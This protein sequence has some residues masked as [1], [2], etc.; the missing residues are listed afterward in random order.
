MVVAVKTQSST[1]PAQR[2]AAV[3]VPVLAI[4]A[5]LALLAYRAGGTN[6]AAGVATAAAIGLWLW[7]ARRSYR[8]PGSG[9]IRLLVDRVGEPADEEAPRVSHR[10]IRIA[11]AGNRPIQQIEVRLAECTPTPAWFVPV[12]LQRLR[13][14]AHPFDLSPRTEVHIDLLA[15]PHGHPEII[16]V[17]DSS[18]HG[19]LPNG[20][21]LGPLELTVQVTARGLP[22]ASFRFAAS[23]TAAGKLELVEKPQLQRP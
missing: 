7:S 5:A 4:S 21:G 20:I 2:P 1:K 13:G 23:R 6:W 10:R 15:L 12:R 9:L 16:L 17:H 19:G 18:V 3:I 22:S 8:E 14:G 11:N